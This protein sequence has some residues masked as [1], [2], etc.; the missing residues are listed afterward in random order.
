[1]EHTITLSEQTYRALLRQAARSQK[2]VEALVE[3]WLQER[4]DLE[5]GTV[6]YQPAAGKH[7]VLRESRAAEPEMVTLELPGELYDGLRS[8]GAEDQ[9][10]PVQV[11]TG[12]VKRAQLVQIEG[13]P[14]KPDPETAPN[15]L[16]LIADL[17]QDLGVE[18]LA[19]QHDHYLYGTEK[20]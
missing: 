9:L 11:L 2:A 10:D 16:K 13:T 18:D 19:E 14:A 7:E 3:E 15:P 5:L 12:L 4:L 17:A 1:M 20:R 6:G 8:L